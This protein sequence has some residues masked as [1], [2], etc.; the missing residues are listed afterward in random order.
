MSGRLLGVSTVVLRT[1]K[2]G[3]SYQLDAN[4]GRRENTTSCAAL[5]RIV[6]ERRHSFVDREKQP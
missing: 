3:I 1:E 4:P 5:C 6:G 2:D